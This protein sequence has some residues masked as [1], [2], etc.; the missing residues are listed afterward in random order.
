LA[1][2]GK[3]SRRRKT[4]DQSVHPTRASDVS[5]APAPFVARPFEGLTGETDWVAMREVVPAA[6]ATVTLAE[7]QLP[8]NV[9]RQLPWQ[10]FCH[11]RGRVCA[12]LT[13]R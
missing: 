5:V 1:T 12:A 2:M 6:T 11:C 4:G 3:A 8:P 7:V 10:R 9:H 13:V